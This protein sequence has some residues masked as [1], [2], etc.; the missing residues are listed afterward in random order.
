MVELITPFVR[1]YY[2]TP[3]VIKSVLSFL[4]KDFYND[5]SNPEIM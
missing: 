2:A 3:R 1:Y 5:S 4:A